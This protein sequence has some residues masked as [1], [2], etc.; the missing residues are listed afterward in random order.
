MAINKRYMVVGKWYGQRWADAD[1]EVWE[2][3]E[4]AKRSLRVRDNMNWDDQRQ[5]GETLDGRLSVAN[6]DSVRFYADSDNEARYIDIYCFIREYD[7][8]LESWVYLIGEPIVRLTLGPRG[9][10][11]KESF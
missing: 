6:S 9:G 3:M 11:R 8:K 2:S 5:L 1:F 7:E 4:A 10:V